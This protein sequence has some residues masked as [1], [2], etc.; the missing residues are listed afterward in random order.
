MF[1]IK[2]PTPVTV[3]MIVV[4]IAAICT[5][6][7]PAG[8][9]NTLTYESDSFT[10]QT[11][12]G[13]IQAPATQKTLDSLQILVPLEKFVKGDIRKPVSIPGTY[14]QLTQNGQGIIEIIQAPV[15]GIYDTIDIILFVLIIG[16]F[17][18][19]F[20]QTGAME[21][22]LAALAYRMK[23]K[24]RWLIIILGFLFSFAGASYGMAEEALAFYPVMVP[25]FLAA[26]YDLI[27]PVA[28]LFGGTQLGTL[29]SFTNPFS[30]IIASNA[31]GVSWTDGLYGRIIMF[32]ISTAVFIFYIERYGKKIKKNPAL[33]F[34]RKYDGDIKS[35][36]PLLPLHEQKNGAGIKT[37]LLLLLF[38]S[39]FLIMIAGVVFFEWWLTEM[40]ALFLSSAIIIAIITRIKERIFIEKFI[41]GAEGLLGVAFIIGVARGVTVILN[42]GFISDTIVFYSAEAI[43]NMPSALFIVILLS[44][45]LVFTLFISSSSGMA[46]VTMP[47]MGS[48]AIMAGVP[49]REIVNAYLFGMGIMGFITPT[50]MMLPSLALVNVSIKAWIRFIYPLMIIL[51][52]LCALFLII[53][54][55]L[56]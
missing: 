27:I 23:G 4:I 20:Q 21:K 31:A 19:V 54:I 17:M 35:P 16:G 41:K 50:G 36:Y 45:F 33:S 11:P 53:G 22:G 34:V 25:L 44:L 26:G 55:N 1:K 30:T 18:N 43:R 47:I 5:W 2:I 51:F 6:L 37:N 8:R 10:I 46:V 48:L 29:S 49:G 7:L 32:V 15:K 24:E 38:L 28:V 13:T 12:G 42:E 9:F 40:S 3:L 39:T 56:K 14:H 52:I